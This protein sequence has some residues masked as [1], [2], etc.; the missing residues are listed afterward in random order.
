MPNIPRTRSS[1]SSSHVSTPGIHV[2]SPKL[3]IFAH[4]SSAGRLIVISARASPIGR[5]LGVVRRRGGIPSSAREGSSRNEVPVPSPAEL[6]DLT[7]KV[8]VVT[9][10]S[11]GIGRAVSLRARGRRAPTSSSRAASSRTA[12]RTAAEITAA[13]GTRRGA[14]GG[15]R[16]PLGPVR[17]SRRPGVRGV[18][19]LRG[20]HQQRGPVAAV[21][22]PHVGHRGALRQDPRGERQGPV[23]AGHADR[24]AHVRRAT[25][26]R[27]STCRP[28]AR[29]VP[30]ST[31]CRT[32]WRRRV[33]TR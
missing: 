22:R 20:A 30:T 13:T 25:A 8:A 18:R 33:S 1:P 16:E 26:A 19:S 6:F 9:G 32:R 17:R 31:T 2:R 11:R 21:P 28:P 12:R 15:E 27:S 4:T 23:P 14:D 29:G 5:L 3:P 10:G 7:G 24:R